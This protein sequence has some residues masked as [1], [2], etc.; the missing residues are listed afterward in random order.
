M[1]RNRKNSD[2]QDSS[3]SPLSQDISG[4]TLGS[5]F[6]VPTHPLLLIG[7]EYRV[8]ST[9]YRDRYININ[10]SSLFS[11]ICYGLYLTLCSAACPLSCLPS[12]LPL[13]SLASHLGTH[14]PLGTS[15]T[16]LKYFAPALPLA[17]APEL[18]SHIGKK[19]E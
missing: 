14:H 17:T 1:S 5:A 4:T 11:V 18:L 15:S 12:Y 9:E 6:F 7:T 16:V 8:Q 19:M 3:R 13:A 2:P 10:K